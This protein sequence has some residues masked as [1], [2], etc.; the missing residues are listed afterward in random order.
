MGIIP[1]Q[2]VE[3]LPDI[4]QSQ[5]Y[6]PRKTKNIQT[7]NIW[8]QNLNKI[9]K[10]ETSKKWVAQCSAPHTPPV[11]SEEKNPCYVEAPL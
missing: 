7:L 9:T 10:S 6:Q 1:F 4:Y 2:C 3:V 11:W 8:I 5:F